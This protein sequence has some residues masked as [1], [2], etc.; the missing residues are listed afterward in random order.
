[1]LSLSAR[2]YIRTGDVYKFLLLLRFFE[3]LE[4]ISEWVS[5][6][7]WIL[8]FLDLPVRDTLT[9]RDNVVIPLPGQNNDA[10]DVQRK[11]NVYLQ[12]GKEHDFRSVLSAIVIIAKTRLRRSAN[13]IEE[14]EG[15]IE[16][17]GANLLVSVETE[18]FVKDI[19]S[20]TSTRS[21]EKGSA[22]SKGTAGIKSKRKNERRQTKKKNNSCD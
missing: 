20:V 2:D 1:M 22:K 8:D 19:Y 7:S 4:R 14:L 11:M 17:E 9:D 12:S 3:G 16:N 15:L 10:K 5:M 13:L 18:V 6:N 21:E